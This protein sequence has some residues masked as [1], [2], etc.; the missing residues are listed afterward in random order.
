MVAAGR[1][2]KEEAQRMRAASTA[3][4]R[5]EVA[6]AVQMRHARSRLKEAVDG[7]RLTPAE[8]EAL[9]ERL[10]H[11]EDVSILRGIRRR[12]RKD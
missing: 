6:R 2:T 1:L 7:G 12:A 3:G 10:D 5:E 11:G 4:E 9:V 8:A